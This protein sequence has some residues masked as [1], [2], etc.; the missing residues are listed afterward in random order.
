VNGDTG[1]D[2]VIENGGMATLLQS[3]EAT[4]KRGIVSQIGYLG[5]QNPQHLSSLLSVLIDKS[6]T[7]R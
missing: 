2:I 6:I 4:A 3:M 5:E 7:L 1:V